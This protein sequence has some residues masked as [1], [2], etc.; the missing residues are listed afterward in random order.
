MGVSGHGLH[1]FMMVDWKGEVPNTVFQFQGTLDDLV[2]V[3]QDWARLTTTSPLRLTPP[4]TT[5]STLGGGREH[6]TP[7]GDPRKLLSFLLL[8][9]IYSSVIVSD[10]SVR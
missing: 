10:Q 6:S 8:T 1:G 7:S 4:T 3:L 9:S 2:V 5:P